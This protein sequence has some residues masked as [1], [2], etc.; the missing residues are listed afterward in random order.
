MRLLINVW[1]VEVGGFQNPQ[2][3]LLSDRNRQ[4][5]KLTASLVQDS[6]DR[7]KLLL[8]VRAR[9]SALLDFPV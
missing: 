4:P 6:P 7:F 2:T 8:R 1:K 5:G 3:L 9:Q